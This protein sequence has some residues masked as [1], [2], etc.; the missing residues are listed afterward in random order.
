M[1]INLDAYLNHEWEQH[2]RA[3]DDEQ[4]MLMYWGERCD[5]YQKGCSVCD[6]WKHFDETQEVLK[7]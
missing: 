2:C 4:E 6:A 5:V 1:G 7:C 3:D